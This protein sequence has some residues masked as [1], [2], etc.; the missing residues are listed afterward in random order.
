MNNTQLVLC[1]CV[2]IADGDLLVKRV[3]FQ[4]VFITWF[5]WQFLHLFSGFV[6]GLTG[7]EKTFRRKM[8]NL[9]E[10]R[11]EN[12]FKQLY[13]TSDILKVVFVRKGEKKS[14]QL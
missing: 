12:I 5:C 13:I 2:A 6:K 11:P 1:T 14:R 4:H 3:N 8:G 7:K 10:L 9:K